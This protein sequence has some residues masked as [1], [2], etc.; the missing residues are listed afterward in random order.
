MDSLAAIAS[1]LLSDSQQR[2]ELAAQ[3]VANLTTPGYKRRLAAAPFA[4][5]LGA[6]Q[7]LSGRIAPTLD[8]SPGKVQLTGNPQDLA[9]LGDGFFVVRAGERIGYS[10]NGQFTRT[11]DGNLETAQ[12]YVL[13]AADGGDLKLAAGDFSVAPDGTIVQAGSPVARVALV[14]FGDG[15]QPLD[16]G[17]LLTIAAGVPL[18]TSPAILRQ[19][20][21]ES[22]NVGNADEMISMMQALRRAESAQRIVTTYDE[23]MGRM[24]SSLGQN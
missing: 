11:K 4:P 24:L 15:A 17:G 2:I 14:R 18:E 19:G 23:L 9:I 8:L 16:E 6:A 21:L 10:R 3:N 7:G 1:A 20:A 22:S 12:G 13:Q 5:V